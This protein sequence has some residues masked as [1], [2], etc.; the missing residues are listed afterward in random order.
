MNKEKFIKTYCKNC[1]TQRCMGIETEWFEGC[2]YKWNLDG[3]DP[4]S[5]IERLNKKIM[6][7]AEKLIKQNKNEENDLYY[8]IELNERID[9]EL[10]NLATIFPRFAGKLVNNNNGN[11]YFE[12]NGHPNSVV[13]IPHNWIKWMA[14]SKRLNKRM[15]VDDRE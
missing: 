14:P 11:F 9:R 1:G 6:E 4:A 2:K 8:I 10:Q 13:I 7:L 3:Q 15:T 12:L 5:E